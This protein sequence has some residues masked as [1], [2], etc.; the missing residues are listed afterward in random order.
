MTTETL[1]W[2]RGY[3]DSYEGEGFTDSAALI[4]D[5]NCWSA[6]ESRIASLNIPVWIDVP[7]K[8]A[9]VD[10]KYCA[11][12]G[13]REECTHRLEVGI[14]M[15]RKGRTVIKW[16]DNYTTEDV[17]TIRQMMLRVWA[18]RADIG[19]ARYSSR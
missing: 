5:L 7:E 2:V 4:A 16:T 12:Y 8:M 19:F 15:P 3:E 11:E 1:E 9:G 10:C 18:L 6:P 13:E 17:S 14:L